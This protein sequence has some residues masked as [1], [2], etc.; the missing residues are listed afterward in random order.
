MGMVCLLKNKRYSIIG[1]LVYLAY[2]KVFLVLL[3]ALI[4]SLN[5]LSNSGKALLMTS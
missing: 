1:Y 2:H 5:T 3:Q 4:S